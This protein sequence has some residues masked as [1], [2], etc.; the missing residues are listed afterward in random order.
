MNLKTEQEFTQRWSEIHGGAP[1]SGAVRIWLLISYRVARLCAALRISPNFLTALGLLT[2]I[3]MAA[4]DSAGFALLLLVVSLIMDG[5]DG[6]VAIVQGRESQWGGVLDSIADRIAEACWLYVG[7][8]IGI[9]AWIVI[10][11]WTVASIQ[12]YARARLAS[13]GH[14]EI[15]EVTPTERPV[16]AIFMALALLIVI[17]NLPGLALLA[18]FFLAALLY[19][20][21]RVMRISF[22][23][24][25]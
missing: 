20:F 14:N 15:G 12:E 3:A 23:K 18:Y 1:I 19:S 21:F 13:L 9:S 4:T 17:L 10:S 16:R 22:L 24:L 8:K 7:W 25:R 2:A 11:M 5:I 6:S